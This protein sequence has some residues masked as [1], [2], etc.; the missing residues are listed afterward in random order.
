[1][2]PAF[3]VCNITLALLSM[4]AFV[5]VLLVECVHVA[6]FRC[7]LSVLRLLRVGIE[8]GGAMVQGSKA[9]YHPSKWV[10][11]VRVA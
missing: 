4:E 2:I 6:W 10:G 8:G 3:S 1:M 7:L 11:V 5:F 9:S